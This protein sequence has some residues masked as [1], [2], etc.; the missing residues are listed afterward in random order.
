MKF[1]IL[2][3]A[4]LVMM[5]GCSKN[6]KS[7]HSSSA[8]KKTQ[9]I[10]QEVQEKELEIIREKSRDDKYDILMDSKMGLGSKI[11]AAQD[12]MSG[13]NEIIVSNSEDSIQK[14]EML[15]EEFSLRL[16]DI[17]SQIQFKRMDPLKVKGHHESS[18]YAVAATLDGQFY[19]I[20]KSALKKDNLGSDV[21]YFEENLIR[22]DSKQMMIDLVQARVDILSVFAL[23]NLTDKKKMSFWQKTK[24]FAFNISRGLFG[25]IE[26]PETYAKANEATKNEIEDHLVKAVDS[27]NFLQ[28]IGI[29]KK[30]HKKL[31]S[32]YK[33]IDFDEKK[34]DASNKDDAAI[35]QRKEII[36]SQIKSLLN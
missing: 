9:K 21:K 3:L 7:G 30:L 14:R 25:S 33:R 8:E 36:R 5:A 27:K 34:S 12:I 19:N 23:Q 26:Y 6:E 35:D 16:N 1:S 28:E 32:A 15:T 29:K 13:M 18:F 31:R 11:T 2:S 4:F 22:Q 10:V 17:Y 20:L 24:S